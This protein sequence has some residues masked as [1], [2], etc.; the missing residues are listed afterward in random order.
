MV[1]KSTATLSRDISFK[2]Q[3]IQKIIWPARFISNWKGCTIKAFSKTL[4]LHHKVKEECS[5]LQSNIH[6]GLHKCMPSN[7]D[8]NQKQKI[9]TCRIRTSDLRIICG[10]WPTTVLRS[11]NWAK[12]GSCLPWPKKLYWVHSFFHWVGTSYSN[13]SWHTS[14]KSNYDEVHVVKKE[15]NQ[16]WTGENQKQ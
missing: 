6:V 3:N 7:Q 12:V 1:T 15:N 8:K 4:N 9:P 10:L 16:I 5:I 13:A 11:T 14:R 2:V